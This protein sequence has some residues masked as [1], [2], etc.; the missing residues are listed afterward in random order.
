MAS[1][2]TEDPRI[3]ELAR[4]KAELDELKRDHA[5]MLAELD[6]LRTLLGGQT[7]DRPQPVP[8]SFGISEGTRTDLEQVPATTD[9]FTSATVT[10]EDGQRLMDTHRTRRRSG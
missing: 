7:T 1:T 9:P 2:A 4:V 10:R 3:A 5:A 6:K 8:P